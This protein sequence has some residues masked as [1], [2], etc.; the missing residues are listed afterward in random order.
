MTSLRTSLGRLLLLPVLAL[1]AVALVAC[2]DSE[3]D[4][5]ATATGTLTPTGESDGSEEPFLARSP[6][7]LDSYRYR[8]DVSV[9]SEALDSAEAP[10]GLDLEGD[11]TFN[12]EGAVVNPDR[13]QTATSIDLGILTLSTETIR[14]GEEE[15]TRAGQGAWTTTTPAADGGD[16]LD[17]DISPDSLFTSSEDFD[18]EALTARLEEHGWEDEEANGYAA[19]HFTFTQEEFYEVFET[20][21]AVLPADIDATFVADVWMA[22]EFGVP[23][24]MLIV[25]TDGGGT[26][27]LRLEM[28]L[29]DINTEIAIDPPPV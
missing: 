14:I 16:I 9:A 6:S 12:V 17:V 24:R 28:N 2:G 22:T 29:R 11:L 3:G 20:D 1:G 5:T 4:S 8:V 7:D 27:I 13:E 23:V 25:G 26:E 21:E 15:W 18:Y 19:R 10:T